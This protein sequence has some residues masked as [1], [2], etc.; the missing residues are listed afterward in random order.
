MSAPQGFRRAY[1]SWF[2]CPRCRSW[3]LFPRVGG[4]ASQDAKSIKVLYWCAACGGLS[5]RKRPW[6]APVLAFAFGLLAFVLIYRGLVD[7]FTLA[8]V[9]WVIG[10]L[11]GMHV[12]NLAIERFT[13]EYVA[14][15]H[16]ES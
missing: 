7:G 14:A 6:L 11:F 16:N 2:A 8:A 4:S 1:L 3:S 13:N 9:L 10:V 15:D 5:Q 12:L